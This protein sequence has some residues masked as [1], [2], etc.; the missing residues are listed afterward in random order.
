MIAPLNLGFSQRMIL[1]VLGSLLLATVV[2]TILVSRVVQNET[3]QVLLEQQKTISDMVVRRLSNALN[4]RRYTLEVY[5]SMLHDGEKLLPLESIQKDLD[6]RIQLHRFFNGGLVVL[7]EQGV[8][9]VDSPVVP[10]RVGIDFSDR[11]HVLRVRESGKSVITRPL[12]GRGLNAPVFVIDAPIHTMDGRLLG[13]VFGVTRLSDD[14]LFMEISQEAFGDEASLLVIDPQLGL[15]VTASDQRQAMQSLPEAGID[16]VIDN[17]LAGVEAGYAGDVSGNRLLFA[18][19]QM[20]EMGWVVI[21]TI[22]ESVTHQ[23]LQKL[24]PKIAISVVFFMLLLAVA[25]WWM[26][27]RQLQPLRH[28]VIEIDSM[29]A[30]RHAPHQLPITRDDEIGMLIGA[31]NR[32]QSRLSQHIAEVE[33]RNRDLQRLSEVSA[34]HL[35]EPSRRLLSYSQRLRKRLKDYPDQEVMIELDFVE[36]SAARLRDLIRDI[37]RYLL[38]AEKREPAR[39]LNVNLLIQELLP[40]LHKHYPE[41]YAKAV[42]EVAT[43]PP[44]LIDRPR[45]AALLYIL[46]EN[47][48]YHSSNQQHILIHMSGEWREGLCYYYISDN[49]P[50]VPVAYRERIFSIFERLQTGTR[51][52]GIGLAIAR[53]I[54]ESLNGKINIDQS[55][56]GGARVILVLPDG[57]AVKNNVASV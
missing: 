10:G 5:T 7:N 15:V 4:E 31:F 56:S 8:S 1:I 47:S 23:S 53:R 33:L 44:I 32:L 21:Y 2:I 51:G 26:M 54:V 52:T 16:P 29:V 12:I 20:Q 39:L 43:L 18:S 36:Q 48:L 9:I 45:I 57:E 3:R 25:S 17:V 49:G 24:L 34:H 30:G 46:L 38:A 22:P 28:V 42:I 6:N 37:Q 40:E 55:D 35:M 41:Q 11:E 13:F 27:R 19:S 14:N 50:G